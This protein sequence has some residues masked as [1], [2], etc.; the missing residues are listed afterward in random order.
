MV[1]AAKIATSRPQSP[2]WTGGKPAHWMS[3]SFTAALP[4]GTANSSQ[5]KAM[6]V[7]PPA[8]KGA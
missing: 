3:E 6:S 4:C 2:V 7:T 5:L 8:A 1:N